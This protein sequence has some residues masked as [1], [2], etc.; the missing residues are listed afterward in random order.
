[1][2]VTSTTQ[3]LKGGC[4]VC[5]SAARKICCCNL[6][7]YCSREH[8][9]VD[10]AAHHPICHRLS[11]RRRL[12]NKEEKRLRAKPEDA[13]F[14][15]DVFTNGVGCFWDIYDTRGYMMARYHVIDVM[16]EVKTHRA[17]QAQLDD[18][19]DML[20]LCRSDNV[21][22][23]GM[24]PALML[25]LGKDQECYDFV[26][27][28]E[29]VSSNRNYDWGD[30][31]EPYLDIKDA[32]ASESVDYMCTR[33]S[34]LSHTVSITLLKI[35]LLLDLM[36][37]AGPAL[38]GNQLSTEILR[39]ISE[40]GMRSPIVRKNWASLEGDELFQ[41]IND[42]VSQVYALYQHVHKQNK[43]FWPALIK[44]HRQLPVSPPYTS[45]GDASEM[46]AALAQTYYAWLET[47]GAIDVIKARFP[48]QAT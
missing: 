43:H 11:E 34:N 42:L 21:G 19:M 30:P 12:V 5:G 32:D 46:R 7:L 13:M 41:K 37:M 28:W 10:W 1:M 18:C 33:F 23:R 31:E 29:T 14:P 4:N 39:N 22:V 45:P 26:K 25:R 9:S 38:L 16:K 15:A 35:K 24:V 17:V 36:S 40:V 44:P 20:R 6:V 8:E 3:V 2:T 48:Q 27:W 47:P